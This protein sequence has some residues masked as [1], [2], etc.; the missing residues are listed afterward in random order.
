MP[1]YGV[2]PATEGTGLLPWSWAQQRLAAA[3][4]YWLAT[5]RPDGRPHLMPVWAVWHDGAL[6]FSSTAG[7]RKTRNLRADSR[8]S[9]SIDNG[10]EPVVIEGVAEEV[11]DP[12]AIRRAAALE[13]A[14]Y[15]TE[16][17][18]EQPLFRLAPARAFGIAA[19][20]PTGSP[21]RWTFPA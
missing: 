12:E 3:H 8:C 2:Q 5:V 16:Y 4:E 19:G 18:A 7:S 10:T 9:V 11:T 1:G 20:D 21:T 15:S 17:A 13:K 6:W 14:K